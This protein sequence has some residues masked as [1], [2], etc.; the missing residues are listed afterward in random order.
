MLYRETKI[1]CC[2]NSSEHVTAEFLVL[3]LTVKVL[4]IS[5]LYFFCGTTAQSG[6]K[7]PCF[8][9]YRSHTPATIRFKVPKYPFFFFVNVVANCICLS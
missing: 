9:T 4:K 5:Q 3:Y 6:P 1:I 7:P 2:T 8:E